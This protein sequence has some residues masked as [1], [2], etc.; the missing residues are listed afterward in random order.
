MEI[1]YEQGFSVKELA[2]QYFPDYLI[3]VVPDLNGNDR[4]AIIS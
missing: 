3:D 1:G 2:R 4:L